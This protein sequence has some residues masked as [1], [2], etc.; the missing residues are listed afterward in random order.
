LID[1]GSTRARHVLALDFGG[2][3]LAAAIVD[4][5]TGT[6]TAHT[7]RPTPAPEGADASLGVALEACRH[8]LE[9][10]PVSRESLTAIGISFGGPVSAN[11]TEVIRSMHVGAW[12]GAALPH[13]LHEQFGLPAF[14]ENDANAAALA[15]A[16]HGAGSEA[17]VVL[18]VQVST[19]IGAGLVVNRVLYRGRGGGGELGHVVVDPDG[20]MCGCGN[21]GCLES[22]ASGWALARDAERALQDAPPGSELHR[23]GREHSRPS[24]E[25]LIAAARH[26]DEAA[27]AILQPAFSALGI[28]IANCVNLLDPDCVVLGGGITNGGDILVP[29]VQARLAEHVVAHLRDPDRLAVSRLGAHA[30]LVGAAV[31]ADLLV[32]EQAE[33][34]E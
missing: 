8:V 31:L 25:T 6:V 14:M 7:R 28:A 26:G 13:T 5:A 27:R 23:L 11:R 17:G 3:K 21:R 22:V 34:V 20:P 4:A 30:P 19:G 2:T 10:S 9:H 24:A 29:I 15:E 18:Y 32:R 12:D 33:A 16:T 1:R